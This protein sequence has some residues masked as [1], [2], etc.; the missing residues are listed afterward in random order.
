MLL[1]VL[2]FKQ[3]DFVN[4]KKEKRLCHTCVYTSYESMLA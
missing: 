4:T 1:Y 3:D 2:L